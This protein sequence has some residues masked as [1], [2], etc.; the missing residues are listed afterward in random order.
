[1]R[2]D[3]KAGKDFWETSWK[4]IPFGKYQGIEK[5]LAI[6]KKLDLLF[7]QFLEKGNKKVLEIGCAKAKK[8]IYFAKEFDYEVYGVDYSEKGVKIAKENLRIA[9]VEGTILCEDIFQTTFEKETFDIVYSMGLIEHFENPSRIIDAHIKLLKK[10]GTLIISIPNFKESLYF[11]LLKILGK[12]K[13]LLETHNLD[14]MDKKKLNELLQKRNIKILKLDYFGPID[15]TMVF[16]D[17][18]VKPIVYLMHIVNQS[19]GYFTFFIPK[20]IYFSPYIVL[21]AEKISE[22]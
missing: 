16:S 3:D 10:G 22:V 8:L 2:E 15:L 6:N 11:T 9:G 7:K 19:F 17:I 12:E 20:S 1:M 18:K 4:K 14:I 21:I 13:R 5:Y